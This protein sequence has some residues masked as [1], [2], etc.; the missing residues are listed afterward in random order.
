MGGLPAIRESK[1]A[2]H[3]PIHVLWRRAFLLKF[4]PRQLREHGGR[5]IC[6]PVANYILACPPTVD[7]L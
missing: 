2:Q 4:W 1:Y 7:T 6:L 5:R 3:W